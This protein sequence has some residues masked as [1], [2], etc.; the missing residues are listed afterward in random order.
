MS[1]YSNQMNIP[2]P[3]DVFLATDDY[4]YDPTA[5][6]ATALLSPIR[7]T[8]STKRVNPE[9]NPIDIAGLVLSRMGSAIHAAVNH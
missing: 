7:Q 1:R 2:L 3:L 5:I 4:D 6:S 9:D 8:V